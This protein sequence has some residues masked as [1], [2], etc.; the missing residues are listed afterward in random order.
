MAEESTNI[1]SQVIENVEPTE[2]DTN[3]LNTTLIRRK[4]SSKEYQ[5]YVSDMQKI[6]KDAQK[7]KI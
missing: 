5:K 7:F 1:E 6:L 4:K 3:T 2:E